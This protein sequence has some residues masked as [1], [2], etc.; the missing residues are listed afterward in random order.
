MTKNCTTLAALALTAMLATPA[1]AQNPGGWT[2][3]GMLN[4]QV[5]PSVGFIVAGH[6]SMQ[7]LFTQNPPL[8]PQAY[9]GALNMAGLNA[10]VSAGGALELGCASRRPPA[11]QPG[12]LPAIM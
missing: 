8:P 5:N 7:C 4:C 2:Q 1:E 11:E 10:G 6:Q 3:V 12:R 9:E